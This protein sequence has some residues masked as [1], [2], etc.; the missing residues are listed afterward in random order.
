M[1]F[2]GYYDAQ[3]GNAQLSSKLWRGFNPPAMVGRPELGWFAL[4]DFHSLRAEDYTLTQGGSAGTIAVNDA[5]GS[6]GVVAVASGDEDAG[7]G[8]SIQWHDGPALLPVANVTVCQE[9]RVQVDQIAHADY[10]F[11]MASIDTDILA[12]LPTDYIGFYVTD[13]GAGLSFGCQDGTEETEAD[14][15]TLVADTWFKIGW[16]LNGDDSVEI[17]VNGIK[18]AHTISNAAIPD[19]FIYRSVQV[20]GGTTGVA[21]GPIAYMDWVAEGVLPWAS[22]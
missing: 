2:P 16:R 4:E 19:D 12:T 1:P 11:G 9:F 20:Q 13:D 14:V 7:D 10:F 3:D 21:P 5:K 6:T 8:P 15:H 17:Y 22:S 18:V